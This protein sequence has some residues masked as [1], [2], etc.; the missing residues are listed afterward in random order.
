MPYNGRNVDTLS[1]QEL[2]DASFDLD[3]RLDRVKE[4]QSTEQFKKKF[5]NQPAPTVNPAFTELQQDIA[6]EIKKRNLIIEKG[7]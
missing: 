5:A 4:A 2:I 6:A 1:D 3:A 7:N